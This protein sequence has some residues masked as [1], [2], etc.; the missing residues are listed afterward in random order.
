MGGFA[1]LAALLA[2]D[3]LVGQ[4]PPEI[5]ADRYLMQAEEQ[6]Q[7]Q[8]F[9]AA[10]AALDRILDLEQEH[11]LAIP[12]AFYFRYAEGLY[13]EA[14]KSVTRYLTT[15]GQD[16]EHY[17]DALRLLNSAEAAREAAE[18][19]GTAGRE[20]RAAPEQG[21]PAGISA[22]QT[23][24]GNPRTAACWMELADQPGCYVWNDYLQPDQTVIWTG[25]CV[26]GWA[27]GTGTL[28]WVWDRGQETRETTGRLQDGKKH[29]RWVLR[30]GRHSIW[31]GSYVDGNPVGRGV[32]R[33]VDGTVIE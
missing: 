26:G 13:E 12:E 7:K 14:I 5:Q 32:H 25:E 8:D 23:C 11:G 3:L 24:A 2:P 28:T 33:R 9:A 27:Q 21:R 22:G 10:K 4:L 18:A 17:V 15:A 6:I 16:G 1:V 30:V 31:E 19:A 29:G 20:T